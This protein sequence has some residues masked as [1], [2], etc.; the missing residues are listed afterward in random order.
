MIQVRAELSPLY[1]A[2]DSGI[3]FSA[4]FNPL[5]VARSHMYLAPSKEVNFKEHIVDPFRA[6]SSNLNLVYSVW[7]LIESLH[8]AFGIFIKKSLISFKGSPIELPSLA[9]GNN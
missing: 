7:P 5:P 2:T 6:S 9:Y 8:G 1:S 4:R 3:D